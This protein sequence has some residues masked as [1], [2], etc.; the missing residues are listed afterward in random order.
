[1]SSFDLYDEF[2]NY[3]GADIDS[4]SDGD[5]EFEYGQQQQQHEDDG[6]V[7]LK[8]LQLYLMHTVPY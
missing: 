4:A 2:G 8:S 6:Q 3:I 5:G 7:R 1:M